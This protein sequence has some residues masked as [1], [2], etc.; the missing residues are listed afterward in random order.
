M[1]TMAFLEGRKLNDPKSHDHAID[2]TTWSE[3]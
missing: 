1:E 2:T 3:I